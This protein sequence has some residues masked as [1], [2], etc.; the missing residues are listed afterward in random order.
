MS[1]NSST[2]EKRIVPDHGHQ[3]LALLAGAVAGLGVYWYLS[4]D[5]QRKQNLRRAVR[6]YGPM[7]APLV[8]GWLGKLNADIS[9]KEQV[10]DN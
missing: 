1:N 8:G 4:G 7:L 10:T 9:T 5:A 2:L 3:T 6:T